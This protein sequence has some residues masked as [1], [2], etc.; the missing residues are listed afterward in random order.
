MIL[1]L[2]ISFMWAHQRV[3]SQR[4]R[5]GATSAGR[6][7]DGRGVHHVAVQVGNLTR[8]L[9]FYHRVLGGAEV[10]LGGEG[11]KMLSFGNT[12]VLLRKASAEESRGGRQLPPPPTSGIGVGLALRMA[13]G[14]DAQGDFLRAVQDRLRS[15]P[16]LQEVVRCQEMS[17]AS[18]LGVDVPATLWP[19]AAVCSGP[20]GEAVEFWQPGPQV[21]RDVSAARKVWRNSA[22]DPRGRDI[23]ESARA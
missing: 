2:V 15:F 22:S 12:V 23:F 21:T 14:V 9:D 13:P 8:S 18:A 19:I 1:I 4:E 11:W 5:R 10:S 3:L 6:L 20:D 7:L 17:V 16:D